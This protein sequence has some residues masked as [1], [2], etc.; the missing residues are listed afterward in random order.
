[1]AKVKDKLKTIDSPV[2]NYFSAIIYSFFSKYLYL[3]VAKRWR[4]LGLIYLLLVTAIASIPYSFKVAYT[5]N[6]LFNTQIIGTLLQLPTILVQSG[7]VKFDKPMPY[8]IRNKEG[9]VV[10]IIDTKNTITEFT[11]DYPQLSI[12]VNANRMSY[13]V[14]TPELVSATMG[15]GQKNFPLVQEFSEQY[16]M[17]FDG[18]SIVNESS[19]YGLKYAAQLMIYPLVVSLIYS[20]FLIVFL[21]LAF[22]GQ[23]FTRI[24]FSH[25]LPFKQS[26]RVFMVAST[27]TIF[28]LALC[29]VLGLNFGGMGYFL[30]TITL[31]YYCFAV[32]HLKA[33][34]RK[35]VK[36]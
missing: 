14:P 16:N 33:D 23:L 21:V 5:F 11:A 17:M 29:M 27:P 26:C 34:S 28:L 24:F 13:K 20:I 31:A 18:K 3:D 12:I 2:Y 10:I 8:L 6:G 35:M 4:G 9:A 25:V 36:K 15:E 1:M 7:K 32:F 19:V 30:I 22:L